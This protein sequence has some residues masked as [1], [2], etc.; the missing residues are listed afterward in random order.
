[1]DYSNETIRFNKELGNLDEFVVDFTSILMKEGIDYVLM[2]GYVA[3][4][5][6]RNRESE[7]I[8]IFIAA[9]CLVYDLT[10]ITNNVKHFLHID[11]LK[12]YTD[13]K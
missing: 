9:T 6:G 5:F 3:I 7:D 1:M 12:V 2:S 8:D 4:L 10:L 11:N 13:L